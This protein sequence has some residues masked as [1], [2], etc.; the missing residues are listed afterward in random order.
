MSAPWLDPE[1]VAQ[2]R[3][4]MHAVAHEPGLSLDGSWRFELLAAARCRAQGRVA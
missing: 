4:P 3:E 1:L 2:G